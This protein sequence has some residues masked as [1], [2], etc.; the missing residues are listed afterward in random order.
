MDE[1]TVELLNGKSIHD[2]VHGDFICHVGIH[3]GPTSARTKK[4]LNEAMSLPENLKRE[5]QLV[6]RCIKKLEGELRHDGQDSMADYDGWEMIRDKV[7]E[8]G[9]GER[10]KRMGSEEEGEESGESEVELKITK[11]TIDMGVEYLRRV[12]S[13]CIYCVSSS[14]SIV[15]LTR[16]CPGG[17]MR[18]PTP[19]SD[20]VPDYRTGNWTKAWQNRLDFFVNPPQPGDDDYRERLRKVGGKPVAEAVEEEVQRCMKQEDEGKYRCK[21]GG[22]IKLFKAEEFWR[23]HLEKKHS[24]WLQVLETEAELVN[25]YVLDPCRVHPPKIEQNNQ[26]GFQAVQTGGNRGF[27]PMMPMGAFGGP[28]PTAGSF[29]P[30]PGFPFNPTFFPG[31]HG[32]G[33]KYAPNHLLHSAGPSLPD[34]GRGRD[35]ANGIGPMRRRDNRIPTLSAGALTMAVGVSR[36]RYAPYA[37]RRDRGGGDRDRERRDRELRDI[38]RQSSSRGTTASG[39]PVAVP[40]ATASGS[41]GGGEAE[42]AVLGR[43]V[44]SYMDLDAAAGEGK[45]SVEELD[46]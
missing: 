17:H 38:T 12:F 11:K 10:E 25:G 31:H 1:S 35:V 20:F 42:L 33:D 26:G 22:C 16:K 21:V 23:K 24:E 4:I 39:P 43:S 13:F 40:A 30:L 3:N 29:Q 36:E 14:D 19:T 46:Y 32:N 18:R 9:R 34:L 6:E 2:E 45:K 28:V 7:E 8:W 44:K 15:E 41:P 37:A 27:A 5:A